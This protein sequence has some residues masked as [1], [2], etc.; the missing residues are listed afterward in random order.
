MAE[1]MNMEMDMDYGV[2]ILTL[3]DEDGE[4]QGRFDLQNQKMSLA[5]SDPSCPR[6]KHWEGEGCY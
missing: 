1:D 3:V 6:K 2:D 5:K 4:E